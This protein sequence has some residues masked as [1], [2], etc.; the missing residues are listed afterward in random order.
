MPRLLFAQSS[1]RLLLRTCVLGLLLALVCGPL[2]HSQGGRKD[3]ASQVKIIC[4]ASKVDASGNQV[5]VLD[6]DISKG[7]HIYANPVGLEDLEPTATTVT[8]QAEP[9]P[10][11]VKVVYPEGKLEKDKTLGNYRIY[12]NKAQIKAYV[13]RATGSGPLHVTVEFNACND[14]GCLPQGKMKVEVK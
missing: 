14:K 11:S 6:L 8:I 10:K 13:Q 3:S 12:E 5:V 1:G 9:K 2:A 4:R 7:W